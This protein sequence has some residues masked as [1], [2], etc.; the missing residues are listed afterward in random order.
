MPRKKIEDDKVVVKLK[1][2]YLSSERKENKYRLLSLFLGIALF[3]CL[4]FIFLFSYTF[5]SNIMSGGNSKASDIKGII[6]DKWVYGNDYDDLD[7]Y[8]D[9]KMLYGMTEF[10]EDPYTTYMSIDDMDYSFNI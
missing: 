3:C 8:L 1:K 6:K 7:R 9:E 2:E 4:I 10:E 5:V